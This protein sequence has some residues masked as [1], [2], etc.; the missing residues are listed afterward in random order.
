MIQFEITDI[1]PKFILSDRNGYALAKAIESGLKYFLTRCQEGLDTLQDVEKMPEWRLD[2]CAW[3]SNCF[4]DYNAGI[5]A[6]R[7]WIRNEYNYIKRHGTAEGIRQYI[8]GQFKESAVFEW[9]EK[10]LTAGYFDVMVNG[11]RTEANEAWIRSA[12][13][14]AKNVRSL[15]RRVI[16]TD[17]VTN[18]TMY[19]ATAIAGIDA[20]DNILMAPEP[21]LLVSDL[22]GMT[23]GH[24]QKKTIRKIQ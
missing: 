11:Q 7:E 20:K 14:R 24:L 4:Y 8:E 2:E 23:V 16:Y 6:K 12:V 18:D 10:S 5:D 1:F 3:E 21:Q 13:E 9:F 22:E 15:L 19:A 17:D